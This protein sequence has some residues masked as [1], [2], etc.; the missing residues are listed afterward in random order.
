MEKQGKLK[1]I[2][3]FDMNRDG[4]GVDPGE[5]RTPNLK[6][7]F[8]QLGR[9]FSKLLSLNM[10]MMFQAL[11]IVAVV[12]LYFFATPTTPT[13]V[14]SEYPVLYGMDFASSSAVTSTNL[15]VF[16]YQLGIPEHGA[17][18]YWLIGAII[19]LFVLTYGWQKVGSI[20]VTRGLVRGD[21]V[22]ILSDFFYGIKKNLKQGFIYGIIDCLFIGI[23]A[24]NFMFFY[25]QFG[26]GSWYID[27]MFVMTSAIIIL[28]II[29]RFYIY[30]MLVT[31]NIKISKAI[32]NALI[33][34]ALGLKRNLMACLGLILISAIAFIPML[35]F[36][37]KYGVFLV[38]PLLYYLGICAFIYTYAAYPVIQKYMIDP[39]PSSVTEASN[40]DAEEITDAEVSE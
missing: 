31:F 14:Y 21:S 32:K 7:F 8:K 2:K 24:Y 34:T 37:P 13:F 12:L 1:K 19:V 38:L 26:M 23:M 28:Y 39:K 3:L 25:P 33:F 35:L 11:P 17:W 20:Y 16:G 36:L 29:M 9:K 40:S 4:K 18:T 30:L 27:L 6:F 5:D 15:S 22:F 10:I